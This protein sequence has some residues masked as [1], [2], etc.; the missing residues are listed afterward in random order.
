MTVGLRCLVVIFV[1]GCFTCERGRYCVWI[2]CS[3]LSF[4]AFMVVIEI[5]DVMDS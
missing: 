1:E 4:C 2:S 3:F 5:E